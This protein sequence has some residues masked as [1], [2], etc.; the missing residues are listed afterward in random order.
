MVPALGFLQPMKILL[1]FLFAGPS[2]A[3]DSLQHGVAGVATPI[4]ASEFGEPKRLSEAPR[5]GQMRSATEVDEVAL[6]IESD[7]F[8][9]RNARDDLC[10]V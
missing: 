7:H 8:I 4:C 10:L 3:V 6:P 5:S 1:Q 9:G 2:R